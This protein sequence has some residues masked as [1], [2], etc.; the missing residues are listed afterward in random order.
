[1]LQISI[2]PMSCPGPSR[3][4]RRA[5]SSLLA[6]GGLLA[7]QAA[8]A[9]TASATRSF[10]PDQVLVHY[11]G[12]PGEKRV[13]VPASATVPDTLAKLR[14]DPAVASAH[15]DY[16][17]HAAR[18]R[19]NDPGSS[20]RGDW[21]RD[22]WN[23]L[24]PARVAGGIGVPAAWQQSI[25]DR[26][27][28]G[29][30]VTVAVLDTGVAY[31]N[32]GHR[33]RR[34]PDLPRRRRFVHPKDLVDGD[35]VP[36]DR[37]GHGTHITSTIAQATD[38]GL[39]LTG[40]AYG[41]KIMP[42]RVLNRREAGKGSDVARGIR[43][44]TKHGADVINLSLNFGPAVRHCD[45]IV[46]VCHAIQH[47]IHERVTVTAAVGN[48]NAP[49]VFYPAVATGVIAVGATTYRGCAASYSNYGAELDVVA[50]GGG[51]DKSVAVT[52]DGRCR[53]REAGYEIPQYSLLPSFAENNDYRRFGIVRLHGTS[54]ASAHVAGVAAL[55]IASHVCGHHPKP[56]RI[57]HRLKATAIDLGRDDI[58]GHG[59]L[60]AARATDPSEPCRA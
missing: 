1:V 59:L 25:R 16:L 13:D 34:D 22:Q 57:A 4:A 55:V 29:R 15:P 19:P 10:A 9:P 52:G 32:K 44:A 47:A 11:R 48:D 5:L 26:D 27:P 14:D 39:G 21:S 33:F 8:H 51:H 43:F 28:G 2:M 56:K 60:N 6:V 12:H 17:V 37:E 31:R 50:P 42:I 24:P 53:P 46:A 7:V 30:G 23:F 49:R 20:G 41:V 58:Y 38:N 54:M 40:I 35:R 36:L 45:Q 3:R 18:F